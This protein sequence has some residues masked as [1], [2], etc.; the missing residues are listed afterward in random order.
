MRDTRPTCDARGILPKE[1]S[2]L[3]AA[4]LTDWTSHRLRYNNWGTASLPWKRYKKAKQ[5]KQLVHLAPSAEKYTVILTETDTRFTIQ[6]A[7]RGLTFSSSISLFKIGHFRVHL[8]LH[9]KTRLSV[10]SYENHFSFILKLELI[11]ITKISHLD[12]LWKRDWGEL[13]NGLLHFVKK[14]VLSLPS[15]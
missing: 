15:E 10:K 6:M 1:E 9:L 5:R 11:T 2:A 7:D 12:P 3:L 13:G 4:S 14:I 8:S